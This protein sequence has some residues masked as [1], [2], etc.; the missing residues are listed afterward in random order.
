MFVVP[1]NKSLCSL[2]LPVITDRKAR[3]VL[4]RIASIYRMKSQSSGLG[5][6]RS[7][8]LRKTIETRA[9][10]EAT[11]KAVKAIHMY[12]KQSR[13][14][15]TPADYGIEDNTKRKK[16]NGSRRDSVKL[17]EGAVV[18]E[19]AKPITDDNIGHRMMLG[20]GWKPGVSLGTSGQGILDPLTAVVKN[21]RR[22]LGH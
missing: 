15:R 7:P 3:A 9:T 8:C 2:E 13:T 11:K 4:H 19:K 5:E 10:G 18:G 6:F 14:R 21:D 20:M 17:A 16:S 1:L 22:G 12:D